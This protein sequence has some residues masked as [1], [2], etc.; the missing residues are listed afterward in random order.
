MPAA[1]D[2]EHLRLADVPLDSASWKEIARFA[3]TFNAYEILGSVA[4]CGAIANARR[5]DTLTDLRTCLFFEQ[6]RWNHIGCTPDE[7]AIGYIHSLLAQIR[8]KLGAPAV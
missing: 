8:A 7:E 2:N 5:N 1:I 4:A 3:H 6:R